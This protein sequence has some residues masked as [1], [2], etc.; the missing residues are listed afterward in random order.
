MILSTVMACNLY[1]AR[2]PAIYYAYHNTGSTSP[3]WTYD[4]ALMV[5][6][7]SVITVALGGLFWS[8]SYMLFRKEFTASPGK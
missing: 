3:T 8:L 4:D 1:I 5:V 2:I 6:N 7:L